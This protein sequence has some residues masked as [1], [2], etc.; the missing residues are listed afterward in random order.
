MSRNYVKHMKKNDT[1]PPVRA[2]ILSSNTGQPVDLTDAT[3]LFIMYYFEDDGAR[4][5]IVNSTAVIEDPPTDGYMRYDWQLGDTTITGNH[6]A[7]FS[8]TFSYLTQESY[9]KRGYIEIRIE[10]DLDDT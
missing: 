4:N 7:L 10:D 8:V 6:K 1:G 9:P 5:E 3:I 2:Q